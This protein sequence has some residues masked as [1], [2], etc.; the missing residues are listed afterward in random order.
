ERIGHCRGPIRLDLR[1]VRGLGGYAAVAT[2]T[3]AT[4][5]SQTARPRRRTDLLRVAPSFARRGTFTAVGSAREREC[6]QGR[7]VEEVHEHQWREAA[8]VLVQ[9]PDDRAERDREHD[10]DDA[11]VEVIRGADRD[12]R[13]QRPIVAPP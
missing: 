10:E 11:A 12:A 1:D 9:P 2:T 4:A 13:H 8:V 7:V 6:E 5:L 3:A